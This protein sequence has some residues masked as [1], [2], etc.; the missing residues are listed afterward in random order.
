MARV[1]ARWQPLV[2]PFANAP[3][4]TLGAAYMFL[5]AVHVALVGEQRE[6][7][8][9]QFPNWPEVA[10]DFGPR[11]AWIILATTVWFLLIVASASASKVLLRNAAGGGNRPSLRFVCGTVVAATATAVVV[12]VTAQVSGGLSAW[13]WITEL[14][15]RAGALGFTIYFHVLDA[16]VAVPM[17]LTAFA[18]DAC[19]RRGGNGTLADAVRE[20][21]ENRSDGRRTIA[22]ASLLMI[23][24]V[25]ELLA[26]YE[27]IAT[28]AEIGHRTSLPAPDTVR[29]IG[30]VLAGGLGFGF[31]IFLVIVYVPLVA[32]HARSAIELADSHVQHIPT[33]AG[34]RAW[35]RHHGL[36]TNSWRGVRQS[37]VVL[38]PL[39][40]GLTGGSILEWLKWYSSLE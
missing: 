28:T 40:V 22:L 39:I 32:D 7:E 20:L 31:S 37:L 19:R 5:A 2:R 27:W 12:T 8:H 9:P 25:F 18:V 29:H 21:K 15:Q 24:G 10:A 4:F 16:A 14:P 13:A 11:V 35:L 38:G 30:R 23:V 17:V 1:L 6:L 33:V 26:L 34:R 3:V 36:T